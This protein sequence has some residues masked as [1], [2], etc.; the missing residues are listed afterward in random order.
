MGC[1]KFLSHDRASTTELPPVSRHRAGRPAPR[2]ALRAPRSALRAPRS[3]HLQT[4]VHRADEE[5]VVARLLP[6]RHALGDVAVAVRDGDDA[7]VTRPDAHAVEGT[8]AA[9][10]RAVRVA[11]LADGVLVRVLHHGTRDDAERAV[12]HVGAPDAPVGALWGGEDGGERRQ[13][14]GGE[15]VGGKGPSSAGDDAERAVLHV[16]APDAPVE[17]LGAERTGVRG[18][19]DSGRGP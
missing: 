2:S 1:F 3:A 5:A 18:T 14:E 16:G 17:A 9:A 15:T 4:V 7:R 10:G 8:G 12:L 11:R 13:R 19:G 6:G